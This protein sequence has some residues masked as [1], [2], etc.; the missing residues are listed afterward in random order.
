[1]DVFDAIEL[2]RE[3][4]S[5]KLDVAGLTE[6]PFDDFFLGLSEGNRIKGIPLARGRKWA[7]LSAISGPFKRSC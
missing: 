7:K 6:S 4:C 5:N 2:L 1:M 3:M